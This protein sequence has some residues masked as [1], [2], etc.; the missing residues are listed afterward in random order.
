[1][2][3]QQI[4]WAEQ[5]GWKS[6]SGEPTLPLADW[7]LAFGDRSALESESR[8]DEL[9]DQFPHATI[10]SC[11]SSGDIQGN[12]LVESPIVATAVKFEKTL[13]RS[14]STTIETGMNHSPAGEKLARELMGPDLRLVFVLSDGHN[15][16]AG[17]LV[18]GL[19]NVLGD[20]V[21]VTGGLAGDGIEFSKTIVGLDGPPVSNQVAAIGFYGTALKVGHGSLGGW[22]PIGPE[23]VITRSKN[24]TLFELDGT[25]ALE[26]YKTY[27]GERANELP[28]A[29]LLFPLSIQVNETGESVVRTVLSVNEENQSMQFAGDLPEGSRCQLMIA[30]FDRIIDASA[31]AAEHCLES[32]D[33]HDTELGI[34]ISCVGRRLLLGSRVEEELEEAIQVIGPQ[35][36]V[37][38]FY[39]YGELSP[40]GNHQGCQLHNQTMTITT[41]S[42]R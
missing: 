1:M 38:G 17:E 16:N 42:E 26:L 32:M 39:S 4:S 35:A 5:S 34:F 22:D 14:A 31:L 11:S 37:T 2:K 20:K 30:N 28:G 36:K 21:P 27:L 40:L 15:V 9:K 6:I 23:R 29:A 24:N 12:E 25:S 13:L 19:N 18:Q 41:L 3:I 8:F 7:V 33:N 10:L